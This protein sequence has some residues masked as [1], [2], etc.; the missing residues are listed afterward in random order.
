MHASVQEKII[1]EPLLVTHKD[2]ACACVW[3]CRGWFSF[4]SD[5]KILP[6]C[7]ERRD[8]FELLQQFRILH[9]VNE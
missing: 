8:S 1:L 7:S 6:L 2:G 3:L 9:V 5:I 4:Y